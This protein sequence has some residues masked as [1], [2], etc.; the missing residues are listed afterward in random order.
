M[1]FPPDRST[2]DE[3][4]AFLS[5]DVP[6]HPQSFTLLAVDGVDGSG[7]STFA[8]ALADHLRKTGALVVLIQADNFHHLRATRY[9]LGRHSPEGFWLDSYDYPA[10]FRDAIHPF[11]PGGSGKYRTKA[12]DLERD[13]YVD[14]PY[15]QALPGT[16]AIIEG[17]FL[18]RDELCGYWDYSVFLQVPFNETAARM[19]RRDGSPDDP[20]HPDMRRYVEGQRLYFRSCEPWLRASR[21]IDNTDWE[22]P[23]LIGAD[24][25]LP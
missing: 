4:I 7:K 23:Q 18:H 16:V 13:A 21:V 25:V 19:S 22:R 6:R 3:L 9:R 11:A 20:E 1:D 15:R 8:R 24:T 10:L 12:S 17:M 14:E 2:R 5:D